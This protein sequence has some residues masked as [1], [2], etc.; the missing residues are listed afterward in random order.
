M[1]SQG[2]FWTQPVPVSAA[3]NWANVDQ[4]TR[5]VTELFSVWQ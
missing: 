5:V 2:S 3:L 4:L 1:L